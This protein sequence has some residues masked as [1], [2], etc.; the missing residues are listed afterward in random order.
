[1][2]P[3]EPGPK[4]PPAS[5]LGAE[6]DVADRDRSG[7]GEAADR[8]ASI[9]VTEVSP[10]HCLYQDALEFHSQ[11]RLML[12]KSESASSRLARA[13]LLLY[14]ASAEALVHQAAEELALPGLA[15]LVADP[16]RPIPLAD[17]WR[18]LP[19]VVGQGHAGQGDPTLAPWPQFAELLSLR[20]SWAFPGP[21]QGRRAYYRASPTGAEFEPLQPHQLP[22]G[23]GVTPDALVYPRT[24]LPRDPYALRPAH[25]DTARGI[26][27]AAIAALDHK[28][29]GALARDNRHRRE[30]TRLLQPP[31]R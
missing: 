3:G 5:A 24:G 7:R 23:V 8:T 9:L 22:K 17:A 30:P 18:L 20:A 31:G 15:R 1:M 11:S 26:L 10:F 27:D 21:A 2:T 25:L 28:L 19:A 12:S 6:V 14:V 29:D 4:G 13:A 16:S